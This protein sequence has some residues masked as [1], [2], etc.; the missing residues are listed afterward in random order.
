MSGLRFP[1][2]IWKWWGMNT[3]AQCKQFLELHN[4]NI[5][6][7]KYYI[8]K[9]FKCACNGCFCGDCQCHHCCCC[10]HYQLYHHLNAHLNNPLQSFFKLYISKVWCSFK[11]LNMNILLCLGT[12][13]KS[14]YLVVSVSNNNVNCNSADIGSCIFKV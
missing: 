11:A 10:H 7:K 12:R 5:D 9:L 2:W 13:T 3:F 6:S 1:L 14:S 4:N 8:L